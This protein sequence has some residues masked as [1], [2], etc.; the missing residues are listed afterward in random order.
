MDPF[1]YA[2]HTVFVAGGTSGINL[3]IAEAFAAHGANVAVMS[4]NKERVDAAVKQLQTHGDKA[5]GHAA[6]VRDAAAV[7][8]VLAAVHNELGNIDVLVSGAAGNFPAAV[9]GMSPNAFKAVVDIDLLGTFNV[10]SSAHQYLKK[11]GAVIINISAPQSVHAQPLQAHVCAAKAGVDQLTR[12]LAIEWGGDGI[13]VN[14]IIPGPIADT[15]GM[16]RLTPSAEMRAAAE[17]A[18]PLKRFG[19]KAE[20]AD[21]ALFLASPMAAYITGAIVPVDGGLTAS[22]PRALAQAAFQPA[23]G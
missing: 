13:R 20:V 19:T 6:D 17:K 4:R 12:V 1:D 11:P 3:A 15:E 2:R 8:G 14:S 21:L 23:S 9:L 18:L 16:A 7:A 10:V 5:V 22:G